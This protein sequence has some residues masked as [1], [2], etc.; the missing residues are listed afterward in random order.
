MSI[1][2]AIELVNVIYDYLNGTDDIHIASFLEDWPSIPFKIRTVSQN[3]LPVL[4]FLPE[5]IV[6]ENLDS[7]SKCNRL[8]I[9]EYL[10]RCFEIK[11][12]SRT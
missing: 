7:T 12:F 11:A 10:K 1:S 6:E 5:L 9:K 2:E 8:M 3:T 4:S